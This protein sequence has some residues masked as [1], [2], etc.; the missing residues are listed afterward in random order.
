MDTC[1]SI[2]CPMRFSLPCRTMNLDRTL[3]VL[4]AITMLQAL[5]AL[6]GLQVPPLLSLA[7]YLVNTVTNNSFATSSAFGYFFVAFFFFGYID[8]QVICEYLKRCLSRIINFV[9]RMLSEDLFFGISL[10][11]YLAAS[12]FSFHSSAQLPRRLSL[13]SVRRIKLRSTETFGNTSK[14]VHTYPRCHYTV[15]YAP[16][17]K[18]G[19]ENT[20]K[21]CCRHLFTIRP[22]FPSFN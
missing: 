6:S 21:F 15:M 17:G 5:L 16:S 7:Q 22:P 3:P 20:F 13:S 14:P 10:S 19:S 8:Q 2:Y 4:I 11:N 12:F 9:R 1:G 18:L